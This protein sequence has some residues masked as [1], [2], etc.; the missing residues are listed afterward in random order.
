M[1][2]PD[3]FDTYLCK[4]GDMFDSIAF[5]LYTD[6]SMSYILMQYNPDYLDTIIFSGGE[7]LTYPVYLEDEVEDVPASSAPW[8]SSES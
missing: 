2:Q 8:Y 5:D 3:H 1:L 4:G 7:Q 6:E